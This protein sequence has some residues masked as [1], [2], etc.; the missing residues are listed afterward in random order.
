M[1]LYFGILDI[2]ALDSRPKRQIVP[3]GRD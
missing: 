2:K 3:R 1:F